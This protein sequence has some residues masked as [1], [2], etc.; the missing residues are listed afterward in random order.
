MLAGIGV[1]LCPFLLMER[2]TAK[3]NSSV[4]TFS[5]CLQFNKDASK[6]LK[7]FEMNNKR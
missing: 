1:V 4:S 3:R 5:Y 6:C 7:I 2:R